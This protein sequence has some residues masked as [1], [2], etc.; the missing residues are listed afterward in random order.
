MDGWDLEVLGSLPDHKAEAELGIGQSNRATGPQT[1][2]LILE[3]CCP[4]PPL[5]HGIW[6]TICLSGLESL[7]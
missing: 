2:G 3:L 5:P 4:H 1:G 7:L 6:L